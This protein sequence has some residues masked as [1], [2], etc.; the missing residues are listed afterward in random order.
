[1]GEWSVTVQRTAGQRC[2]V[3]ETDYSC[4]QPQKSKHH[5]AQTEF[6]VYKEQVPQ[7]METV[8]ILLKG[9]KNH[10]HKNLSE[11]WVA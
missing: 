10:I 2:S 8:E 6:L 4:A 7:R 1:M 3:Q 11:G 5:M 9:K